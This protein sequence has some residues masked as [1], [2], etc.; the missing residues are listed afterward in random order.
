M[1][2]WLSGLALGKK[3][4]RGLGARRVMGRG[5]PMPLYKTNSDGNLFKIDRGP[6]TGSWPVEHL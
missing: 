1:R 2:H 3:P 5:A 4:G 6:A